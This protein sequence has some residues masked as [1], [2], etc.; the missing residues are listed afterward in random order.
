M[1]AK[2]DVFV[3]ANYIIDANLFAPH[4]H[5]WETAWA[6]DETHHWHKCVGCDE[7]TGKAEHVYDADGKCVC[8]AV[9]TTHEHEHKYVNKNVADKYL[10]SAANCTNPAVYYFSCACGDVGTQTFEY[11]TALGHNFVAG[12]VTTQPTCTIRG[13][14]TYTCTPDA[15]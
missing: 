12:N 3:Y 14:R 15:V 2:Y 1:S 10:K 9:K 6:F 4:V 5:T 13:R 8:G 7:I 11:G